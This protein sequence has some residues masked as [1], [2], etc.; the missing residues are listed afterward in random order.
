MEI[1][2]KPLSRQEYEEYYKDSGTIINR[3]KRHFKNNYGKRKSFA[4]MSSLISSIVFYN[5][6]QLEAIM[7]WDIIPKIEI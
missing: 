7:N 6:S 4:K 2:S 5:L 3:Y 1:N